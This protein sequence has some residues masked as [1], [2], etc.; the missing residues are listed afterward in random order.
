MKFGFWCIF[1]L[2]LRYEFK[3]NVIGK[4]TKIYETPDFK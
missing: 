2:K 3:R 1:A 4:F